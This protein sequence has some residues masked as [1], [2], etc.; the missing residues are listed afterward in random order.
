MAWL[1]GVLVVGMWGAG[2]LFGMALERDRAYWRE[3]MR[4]LEVR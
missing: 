2:V 1:V 3:R 4:S